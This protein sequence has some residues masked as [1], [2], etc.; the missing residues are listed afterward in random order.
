MN[1]IIPRE[2]NVDSI[3]VDLRDVVNGSEL[4]DDSFRKKN[5][6]ILSPADYTA[7]IF[8]VPRQYFVNDGQ[9]SDYDTIVK[10]IKNGNILKVEKYIIDVVESITKLN[11]NDKVNFAHF[12]N[13]FLHF[14]PSQCKIIP[15]A[16]NQTLIVGAPLWRHSVQLISVKTVSPFENDEDYGKVCE[17]KGEGICDEKFAFEIENYEP[18]HNVIDYR[19]RLKKPI[20]QKNNDE[21]ELER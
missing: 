14:N 11:K 19:K 21:Q 6:D 18:G 5:E 9:N 12:K 4:Q 20:I 17:I 3:V 13:L 16:E 1:I 2:E 8:C 15:L 10:N 7:Y